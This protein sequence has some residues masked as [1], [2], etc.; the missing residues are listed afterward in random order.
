MLRFLDG[1]HKLHLRSRV[2]ASWRC[3]VYII[4]AR[5]QRTIRCNTL[6]HAATHCS[7]LQRTATLCT[8]LQPTAAHCNTLQHTAA[9]C[10]TLHHTATCVYHIDIYDDIRMLHFASNSS[11]FINKY[12]HDIRMLHFYLWSYLWS[13]KDLTGRLLWRSFEVCGVMWGVWCRLFTTHEQ[14]SV[15]YV[16]PTHRRARTCSLSIRMHC[17]AGVTAGVIVLCWSDCRL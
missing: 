4:T 7:A 16:L 6:H 3:V 8:T 15:H 1:D 14:P 9:H 11:N 13:H 17:S 12:K 5:L 2:Y 10:N